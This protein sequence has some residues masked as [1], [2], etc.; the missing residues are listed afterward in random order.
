MRGGL[1]VAVGQTVQ[2]SVP[3]QATPATPEEALL[4]VQH[5]QFLYEIR[6]RALGPL[7]R[8]TSSRARVAFGTPSALLP[9][10]R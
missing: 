3:V 2:A 7:T 5:G 8:I 10:C 4:H 6:R 9:A 1:S